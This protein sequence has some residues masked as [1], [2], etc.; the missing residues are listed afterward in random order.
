MAV[1][2]GKW[3]D[4][5]YAPSP[6]C[7]FFIPLSM[8]QVNQ[9]LTWKIEGGIRLLPQ[10]KYNAANC[11][12]GSSQRQQLAQ[13]YTLLSSP[14][15]RSPPFSISSSDGRRGTKDNGWRKKYC[16]S[17]KKSARK[18]TFFSCFAT[19]CYPKLSSRLIFSQF[20]RPVTPMPPRRVWDPWTLFTNMRRTMSESHGEFEMTF[21]GEKKLESPLQS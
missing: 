21:N 17:A 11:H 1:N 9:N 20:C 5:F 14:V 13:L 8:A 15:P 12:R 16:T 19:F 6:P 7:S 10:Q 4:T 2:K 3:L 18:A